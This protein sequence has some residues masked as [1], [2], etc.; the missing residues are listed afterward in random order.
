MVNAKRINLPGW[1]RLYLYTRRKMTLYRD[2]KEV[3]V[4]STIIWEK[5]VPGKKYS[6]YKGPGV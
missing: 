2:L 1:A 4:N 3:R 6:L 5:G